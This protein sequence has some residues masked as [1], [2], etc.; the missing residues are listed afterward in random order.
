M[1][2]STDNA[3]PWI[4]WNNRPYASPWELLLVPSSH[5]ARL[6]WEYQLNPPKT[7]PNPYTPHRLQPCARTI[8]I[9]RR[10]AACPIRTCW[11]LPVGRVVG[12][13][14][15]APQ[16]YRLLEYVGVPSRFVQTETFINP[17][18]AATSGNHSFHPPFNRISH[19]REP[20]RI[21]LN[22][23]YSQDVF[24]GLMNYFPGTTDATNTLWSKFVQSRRGYGASTDPNPFTMPAA[25]T[26]TRFANPFRSFAGGDMSTFST[27]RARR[28]RPPCCVPTRTTRPGRCSKSTPAARCPTP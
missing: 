14:G 7:V 26:P 21:N 2:A 3:F 28:S 13:N 19:Y 15:P 20:G 9:P 16:L 1:E 24:N 18:N 27:R 23:I 8:R 25:G 4:A 6:L 11:I 17:N 10:P 12:R 22:T 5:P